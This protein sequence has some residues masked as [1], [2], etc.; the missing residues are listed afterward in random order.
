[1]G[2]D[3]TVVEQVRDAALAQL[4]RFMPTVR[5]DAVLTLLDDC[6]AGNSPA[7]GTARRVLGRDPVG[8]ATWAHDHAGD[9]R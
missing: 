8:F 2:R 4:S 5:A 7:T 9:F 1:M 3:L 6:A